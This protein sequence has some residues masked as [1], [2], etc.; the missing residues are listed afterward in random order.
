[1]RM[2]GQAAPGV[3]VRRRSLAA[4]LMVERL[5]GHGSSLFSIVEDPPR[6]SRLRRRSRAEDCAVSRHNR[7]A[8]PAPISACSDAMRFL[9]RDIM[10]LS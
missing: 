10:S 1:M 6:N 3:T 8:R 2:D 7:G 4:S 5:L 9:F